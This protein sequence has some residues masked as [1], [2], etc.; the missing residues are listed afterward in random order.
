MQTI[1][2]PTRQVKKKKCLHPDHRDD[3]ATMKKLWKIFVVFVK[4]SIKPPSI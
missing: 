3:H 4:F 2:D 1:S